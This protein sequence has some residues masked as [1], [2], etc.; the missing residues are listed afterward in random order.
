MSGSRVDVEQAISAVHRA[1]AALAEVLEAAGNV[2]EALRV[3][4]NVRCRLR[5][6][7]GTAP[8]PALQALHLR[9]L[10]TGA[11]A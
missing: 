4:D 5:D 8:S 3:Y 9:L 10:R 7:L 6:E 2:A 11:P 1:D